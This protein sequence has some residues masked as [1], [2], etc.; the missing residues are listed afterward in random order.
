ME[1]SVGS[2]RH[3]GQRYLTLVIRDVSDRVHAR[4]A[5]RE[6][7]E[8]FA[9]AFQGA[10]V[11]LALVAPDGTLLRANRALCDLAGRPEPELAGRPLDDL[12]HPADRGVDRVA[13]E[14]MVAGRTERLAIERRFL[15]AGGPTRIARINL[16]LIRD[17]RRDAAA[18]RRPDRGRDG[19]PPHGR[20]AHALPGPLQGAAGPHAGLG[21]HPL[22]PRP[23]AGARGGGA[24]PGARLRP[25]RDGGQ[26]AERGA[27]RAR[28]RPARARVPRGAGRRGAHVRPRPAGR[29]GLLGPDRPAARRQRPHLRRHGALP[30]HQRAAPGR[31]RARGARPRPRAL[32][33]GA[34]A[35]R[36]RRLARPLRAA[37][38]GLLLP[39]AP[40]PPLPG[41]ARRGRRRLHRLRRRRRD[42]D[43]AADRR[44]PHLL[45]R[46]ARR[47]GARARG[48][49][50]GRPAGVRRP[51]GPRRRAPGRARAAT[52]CPRSWATRSSSASCSR[53]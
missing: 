14:A 1:L 51:P 31:A 48:Q 49:R 39:P 8:R 7:E 42:P 38:D 9:G 27:G 5:L 4:R 36:L 32:Q 2:W 11:G 28:A 40:A 16:S 44:P 43:A 35:V 20:G 26:A 46:R 24:P 29:H 10:A 41:P 15:T 3:A 52:A 33:R 18:L 53:T 47:P 30:R 17:S 34:R 23:A 21:D 25:R 13:I 6:A 19:A 22:R 37:A 45:A 50:R 12:L